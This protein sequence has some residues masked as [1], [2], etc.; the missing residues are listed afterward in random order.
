LNFATQAM[1]QPGSSFKPFVLAAALLHGKTLS[2]GYYG[3]S[4]ITVTVDGVRWH[5]SNYDHT[6]YGWLTLRNAT[7]YSVNTVYAQLVRDIGPGPVVD[8]ARRLGITTPLEPN[9]S[10]AL[11]TSNV[12]PIELA[13]AYTAFAGDGMQADPTG[14]DVV[15]AGDQVLYEG[16]DTAR[17]VLPESIAGGVRDAL[18][19]V[20]SYGTGARVRIPGFATYGKTGTTEEHSDAWFVGWAGPYVTAVWVGYPKSMRPMNDVHGIRVT[21]NSFPATI[22]LATMRAAL[23]HAPP[24]ANGSSGGSLSTGANA[25]GAPAP[26]SPQASAAVSAQ[27]SDEPRPSPSQRSF[28]LPIPHIP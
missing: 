16:P 23:Q 21:G 8:M 17:R 7:A 25:T 11:G 27:P 12:T 9:P 13:F 2:D 28:T 6:G 24:L 26:S 14:L 18:S 3:P 4:S 1:R 22:W 10:L 19:A 5:V 20:T 15:R